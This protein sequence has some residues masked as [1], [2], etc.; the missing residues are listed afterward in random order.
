MCVDFLVYGDSLT[1][2][3]VANPISYNLH[4]NYIKKD[5]ATIKKTWRPTK[6]FRDPQNKYKL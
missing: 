1:T 2:I 4:I 6:K 3:F 5:L